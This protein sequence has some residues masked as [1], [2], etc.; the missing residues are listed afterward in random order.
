VEFFVELNSGDQT[1]FIH[2]KKYRKTIE[3]RAGKKIFI[4][5]LLGNQ[6]KQNPSSPV[7]NH[8]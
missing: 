7:S 2:Y 3:E 8:H 4:I 5:P 1:F 6:M